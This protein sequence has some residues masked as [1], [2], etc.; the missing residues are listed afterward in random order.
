LTGSGGHKTVIYGNGL[1][2]VVDFKA[3]PHFTF[4]QITENYGFAGE[5]GEGEPRITRMNTDQHG[6]KYQTA[7]D[8]IGRD[9]HVVIAD[10]VTRF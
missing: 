6:L 7:A 10:D 9:D 1:F 2:E 4:Y 3:V 5:A 8:W